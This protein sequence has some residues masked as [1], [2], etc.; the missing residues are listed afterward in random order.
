M[1]GYLKWISIC[2][3]GLTSMAKLVGAN[4]NGVGIK[5]GNRHNGDFSLGQYAGNTSQDSGEGK[6]QRPSH[7]KGRPATFLPLGCNF[8]LG[9]TN[10]GQLICRLGDAVKVTL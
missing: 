2:F 3:K 4:K 6:I 5:G 10:D 8:K 9:I 7:L 1:E